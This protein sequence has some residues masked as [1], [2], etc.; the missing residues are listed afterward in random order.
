MVGR[1]LGSPP[2]QSSSLNVGG[3]GE[4]ALVCGRGKRRS[5]G[6]TLVVVLGWHSR[7]PSA[8][9]RTG[10]FGTFANLVTHW[11]AVL[12]GCDA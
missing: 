8:A 2:G 5:T 6:R 3:T 7:T 10:V 12:R 4:D 11:D 1:R 9:R